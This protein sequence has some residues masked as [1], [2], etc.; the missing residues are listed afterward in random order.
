MAFAIAKTISKMLERAEIAHAMENG[1]IV[2]RSCDVS[3]TSQQSQAG[4]YQIRKV[5]ERG[6]RWQ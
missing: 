5:L 4:V 3:G 2:S 6:I 1:M